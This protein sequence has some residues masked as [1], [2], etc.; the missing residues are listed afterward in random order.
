MAIVGLLER[1]DT[2]SILLRS[3]SVL[4]QDN[5]LKKHFE[6]GRL[7]LF[8]GDATNKEDVI[9]AW[10]AAI[11]AGGIVNIILF[12]VGPT[13]KFKL[14]KGMTVNPPNVSAISYFNT[15]LAI[16]SGAENP[17][18]PPKMI[19]LSAKAVTPGAMASLPAP[20]R[21]LAGWMFR[22]V[23]LDKRGMETLVY[24][25]WG[26]EYEEGMTPTPSQGILPD[27]WKEQLPHAGWA[28]STV[29][30]RPP[31]LTDDPEKMKYRAEINDFAVWS[32]SRRD[33]AGFIVDKVLVSDD[34]SKRFEGEVVTI[35]Y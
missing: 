7:R 17:T 13:A 15:L 32:I 11:T 10:K 30:I 24:H 21:L 22:N 9:S 27:D 1:G 6:S 8:K 2:V 33:L 5:V 34:G 20:V 23:N 35:G 25:G 12:A 4:E 14:F 29:L 19:V 18:S 26:K 31:R 28:K 3:P 16:T